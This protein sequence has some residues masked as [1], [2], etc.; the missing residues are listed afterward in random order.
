MKKF[1]ISIY[2]IE[3]YTQKQTEIY[4]FEASTLKDSQKLADRKMKDVFTKDNQ[5]MQQYSCIWK[6]ENNKTP[7]VITEKWLSK[8]EKENKEYSMFGQWNRDIIHR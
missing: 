4:E 6:H 7:Y 8:S 3:P 1:T 5:I 2:K